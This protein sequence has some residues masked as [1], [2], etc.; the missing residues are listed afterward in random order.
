MWVRVNIT[1]GGGINII[2]DNFA[3]ILQSD[4]DVKICLSV[5]YVASHLPKVNI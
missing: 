1:R 2:A 4:T 5:Q 3:N